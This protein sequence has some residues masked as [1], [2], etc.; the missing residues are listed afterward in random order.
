MEGSTPHHTTLFSCLSEGNRGA[1]GW[2]Q[3]PLF[4]SA[5]G[6]RGPEDHM[7][8]SL[9]QASSGRT[10]GRRG[11]QR[12]ATLLSTDHAIW[13]SWALSSTCSNVLPPNEGN[14]F[15]SFSNKPITLRISLR[16]LFDKACFPLNW[17]KEC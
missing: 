13:A 10:Q 15:T 4:P 8:P 5:G 1:R 2:P 12:T 14:P 17:A 3:V 6:G 11:L 9:E 7:A 16:F